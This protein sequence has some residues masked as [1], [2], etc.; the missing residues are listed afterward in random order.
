MPRAR[1]GPRRG[2]TEQE[3][4]GERSRERECQHT[5]VD[6]DGRL[7]AWA[8]A[9]GPGDIE[10]QG[11]SGRWETNLPEIEKAWDKTTVKIA[12][13]E[14]RAFSVDINREGVQTIRIVLMSKEGRLVFRTNCARTGR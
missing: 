9:V 5:P 7:L 8:W 2:A 3:T 13:G 14:R 6:A 1:R 12:T 4:R 10:N 11:L